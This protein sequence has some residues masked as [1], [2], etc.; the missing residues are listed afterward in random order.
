MG[1]ANRMYRHCLMCQAPLSIQAK[2]SDLFSWGSVQWPSL[3][4][5]CWA[6]FNTCDPGSGCRFCQHPI[7]AGTDMCQ[8]CQDWCD[9]GKEAFLS[10]QAIFYYNQAFRKW[11]SN[12]KYQGDTRLASVMQRPLKQVYRAYRDYTWTYL[13]SSPKNLAKRG[14]TPVQL[15]LEGAGIN[16]CQIFLYCGDNQAQAKKTKSQRLQ[17]GPVF[18]LKEG[19]KIDQKILIVDDVYTTGATL[20]QAKQCLMQAGVKTVK[21]LTFARDVMTDIGGVRMD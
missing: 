7:P 3:C 17:L 13:P 5:G 18:G 16:T 2:L 6:L 12:Y 9:R 14:F 20:I 15:V 1:V 11:I 21:S 19:V 4:D 8:D 10:N